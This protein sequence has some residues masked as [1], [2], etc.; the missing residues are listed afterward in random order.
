MTDV[1]YHD[2]PPPRVGRERRCRKCG[3]YAADWRRQV[4]E[5]TPIIRRRGPQPGAVPLEKDEQARMV[6]LLRAIG[7]KW[8][9]IGR[10]RARLCWK[11]G[12]KSRDQGTRQTEGIPDI[13]VFLPAKKNRGPFQSPS[14]LWIEAKRVKGSRTSDEQREFR[15][16]C[17]S[18]GI[19]HVVG[20]FDVVAD[21]LTAHHFL[22]AA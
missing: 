1:C 5:E 12:A 19:P 15:D 13:F 22:E 10:P 16:H 8:Y 17:L 18:R 9:E 2:F 7:A 6:A 20:H 21:W 11:C 3:I 4:L 14:F